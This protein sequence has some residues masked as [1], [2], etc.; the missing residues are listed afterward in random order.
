MDFDNTISIGTSVLATTLTHGNSTL[1][2]NTPTS[3][4]TPVPVTSSFTILGSTFEYT[5][6]GF[7]V[8]V[9]AISHNV[10]VTIPISTTLPVALPI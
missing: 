5:I 6:P 8:L 4:A 9:L 2:S 3:P 7:S 1:V 10:S